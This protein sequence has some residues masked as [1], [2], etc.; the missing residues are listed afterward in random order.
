MYVIVSP[1]VC[2]SVML[3]FLF[4]SEEYLCLE[5]ADSSLSNDGVYVIMDVPRREFS[6]ITLFGVMGTIFVERNFTSIFAH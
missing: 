3:S 2:D 5:K 4:L 1:R 6:R